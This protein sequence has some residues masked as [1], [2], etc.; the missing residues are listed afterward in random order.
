MTPM[1]LHS[2]I[3]CNCRYFTAALPAY[4]RRM[5]KHC[6]FQVEMRNGPNAPRTSI[7]PGGAGPGAVGR[8]S[9]RL[10]LDLVLPGRGDLANAVCNSVFDNPSC[11]SNGP[12]RRS[13]GGPS[14]D[15]LQLGDRRMGVGP[16]DQR[17]AGVAVPLRS[18]PLRSLRPAA[19]GR[20]LGALLPSG[21]CVACVR[22]VRSRYDLLPHPLGVLAALDDLLRFLFCPA[23]RAVL[24]SVFVSTC[25]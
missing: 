12:F 21:L 20:R 13:C 14:P 4:R 22:R 19:E 11:F 8:M 17:I 18:P 24:A 3:A 15:A 16:E 23:P 7:N 5:N 1:S 6:A 2:M 9:S 10:P 25:T